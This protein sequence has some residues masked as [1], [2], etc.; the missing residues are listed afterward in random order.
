MTEN[1]LPLNPWLAEIIQLSRNSHSV[2]YLQDCYKMACA[3][4]ENLSWPEFLAKN[5]LEVQ[6]NKN[7]FLRKPLEL[8]D[9][10]DKAK[11]ILYWA[12]V[13]K[14]SDLL[15]ITKEELD[16]ICIK[17]EWVK[18]EITQYLASIGKELLSYSAKTS[19][20]SLTYGYWTIPSPGASHCF[21]IA[22][23]TL[24]EE[25]FKEYY[26]LYGHFEDEEKHRQAFETVRPICMEAELMPRDY[27]EFFQAA[28]NLFDS[29]EDCCA[30]CKIKPRV[31]RP[32][33]PDPDVRYIYREALR[34]LIDILERTTLMKRADVGD[35][36]STQND[37]RRLDLSEGEGHNESFQLLLIC[38]VEVKIDIENIGLTLDECL[39]GQHRN[40]FAL[41]QEPQKHPFSAAILRLREKVSDETLRARYRA[42]VEENPDLGWEEFIVQA[43][44]AEP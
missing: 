36:L 38:H 7:P 20:L 13:D 14:I 27:K 5:S 21:N 3:R 33:M 44:L 32:I 41:R 35:Y 17:E 29:Y 8:M 39:K 24:R 26:R 34:A 18:E 4:G 10:S 28:K 19:K 6:M 37:Q 16:A 43:A 12:G 22:R 2:N 40:E 1:K 31:N 15:Q 11:D 9:I 23:P 30:Y 42:E 25:W